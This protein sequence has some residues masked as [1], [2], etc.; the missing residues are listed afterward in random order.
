MRKIKKII[1]NEI[2]IFGIYIFCVD[3]LFFKFGYWTIFTSYNK[4]NPQKNNMA[5]K[6]EIQNL[7]Q[8]KNPALVWMLSNVK[9]GKFM[10]IK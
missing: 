1:N 5:K 9:M 10:W 2:S 8:K 3:F 4:S 7:I 6:K